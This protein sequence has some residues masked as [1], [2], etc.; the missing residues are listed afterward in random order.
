MTGP[1][2]PENKSSGLDVFPLRSPLLR[3][4]LLISSPP[5]TEMF[6]FSGSRFLHLCIQCKI[7]GYYSQWVPPFGYF[8]VNASFQLTETFRRLA[9][10]S[11]P[12]DTKASTSSPY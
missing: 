2:T 12:I 4:S 7:L 1:A 6:H 8:R 5:L 11:S 10:P 9:R 3:E